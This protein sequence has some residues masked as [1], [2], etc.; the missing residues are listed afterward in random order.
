MSR[1]GGQALSIGGG[2]MGNLGTLTASFGNI[3]QAFATGG[4]VMAGIATLTQAI[5]VFKGAV[6]KMEAATQKNTDRIQ[7]DAEKESQAAYNQIVDLLQQAKDARVLAQTE[8]FSE[9]I[10]KLWEAYAKNAEAAAN[11]LAKAAEELTYEQGMLDKRTA[12]AHLDVD[13]NKN[14]TEQ[15]R[16]EE[17]GAI[18]YNK[19]LEL[20]QLKSRY[21]EQELRAKEQ[22]LKNLE[23]TIQKQK[24]NTHLLDGVDIT[25]AKIALANEKETAADLKKLVSQKEE[26]DYTLDHGSFTLGGLKDSIL[27]NAQKTGD[28]SVRNL[29]YFWG[30]YAARVAVTGG[31]NALY[32]SFGKNSLGDVKENLTRYLAIG[33]QIDDAEKERK[34]GADERRAMEAKMRE[35]ATKAGYG[36]DIKNLDFEGLVKWFEKL[37]GSL[38]D[39]G[40][41]IKKAEEKRGKDQTAYDMAKRTYSHQQNL[42]TASNNLLK[43]QNAASVEAGKERDKEAKA[44]EKAQN[45]KEREALV[46]KMQRYQESHAN[47]ANGGYDEATLRFFSQLLDDINKRGAATDKFNTHCVNLLNAMHDAIIT[48]NARMRDQTNQVQKLQQQTYRK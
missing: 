42:N 15:Q 13:N 25:Q 8:G 41:E 26:L 23:E 31:F 1:I 36:E 43:N 9:D 46:A 18:E 48:Q 45:K 47:G 39:L 17:H 11:E 35:V 37:Q 27:E 16:A 5:S 4:P 6:D 30:K 10:R 24:A 19:Q 44:R 7:N 33:G 29:D 32:D 40:E 12:Q 38:K 2:A 3:A 14:L 22:N 21:D 20:Q 28:F 34:K